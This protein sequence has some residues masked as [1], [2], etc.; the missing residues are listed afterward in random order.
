[1]IYEIS[2]MNLHMLGKLLCAITTLNT[3]ITHET[4]TEN[5]GQKISVDYTQ[6]KKQ[7]LN[8]WF[9]LT[10]K[11]EFFRQLFQYVHRA[12]KGQVLKTQQVHRFV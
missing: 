1:M 3:R 5:K 9:C 6:R 8:N 4:E 2:D 7:N 11:H 10:K 12:A